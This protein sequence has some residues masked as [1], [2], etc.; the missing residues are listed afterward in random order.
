MTTIWEIVADRASKDPS[1][2]AITDAFDIT[3]GELIERTAELAD[4]ISARTAPG[5]LLAVD[6][7][8]GT[9][10]AVALLAGARARCAV[11]PLNQ[12]SPPL[13]RTQLL[14]DAR[15]ALVLKEVTDHR[16]TVAEPGA[17]VVSEQR[18]PS[19]R[20]IAY[21]LY[22]SGS[23]GRPKGVAV[24]HRSL[25]DRIVALARVPGLAAG[26]S[27]VSMTALSFDISLAE[28]LVPLSVGGRFVTAPPMARL[29]PDAFVRFAKEHPTDVV[30]AT[31]SFWR[32]VLQGGWQGSPATR[33]WCG[34]EAMTPGLAR[35]LQPLCRELWNLYGPTEATIWAT[36]ARIE[37]PDTITLGTP[38]PGTSLCLAKIHTAPDGTTDVASEDIVT[39]PG[40]EGEILLYGEG[41][42]LGYLDRDDLSAQAFV[43]HYTPDGPRRVYRTGDR[44]RYLADGGLEFLGRADAQVKLRGHRIELA[45]VEAALEEHD[46]IGQAAVVLRDTDR[47]ESTYIEAFLV[48]AGPIEDR[49]LR[50]WLRSRLSAG[51]QPR[52]FTHVPELPRTTAGKVDRVRLAQQPSTPRSDKEHA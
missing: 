30:Q 31:P 13:R 20:D 15:P 35:Q 23:T 49:E 14:A 32:L 18:E 44:G 43:T 24:P 37:D 5:S 34:G 42:A 11:L 1:A 9:A 10:G 41:L 7:S 4:A 3:Y 27:I 47:P 33:I 22:T 36:A 16:F 45:S 17:D 12:E 52:R 2:V 50:K 46:A 21:V 19:L 6:A 38:L 26:E 8:G 51:E 29:D 48:T 39:E 25:T 28:L 40:Q